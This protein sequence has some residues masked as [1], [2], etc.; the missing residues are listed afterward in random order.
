V[1]RR[2]ILAP[3][4]AAVA[5]VRLLRW[6]G[7]TAQRNRRSLLPWVMRQV[8]DGAMRGSAALP[9]PSPKNLPRM[10]ST[11]PRGQL[12]LT[13]LFTYWSLFGPHGR[14]MI[15]SCGPA[16]QMARI[17]QR[18][19]RWGMLRDVPMA[20]NHGAISCFFAPHPARGTSRRTRRLR[21]ATVPGRIRKCTGI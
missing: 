17:P 11:Q 1:T 3:G 14:V 21:I 6:Q 9:W 20:Q 5:G 2:E 19:L 10:H 8:H 15:R 18:A 13:E 16:G 12:N 4:M 7:D